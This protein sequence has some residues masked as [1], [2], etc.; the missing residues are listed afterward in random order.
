[1]TFKGINYLNERSSLAP[2]LQASPWPTNFR[3][4]TYPKYNDNTDPAQY[5]MSYQVAVASSGG[6]DATMAKSFIIALKGMALTWYTRLP[7]LSI[8]FW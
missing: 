2:Q 3:A 7:P 6:D 8:D 4:G 5:I 1:V